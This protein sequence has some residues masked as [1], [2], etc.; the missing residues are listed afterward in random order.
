MNVLAHKDAEK[1]I[2][3]KVD[4]IAFSLESLIIGPDRDPGGEFD[5]IFGDEEKQVDAVI[6]FFT[7]KE[8]ADW[9][10]ETV[11]LLD[12]CYGFDRTTVVVYLEKEGLIPIAL[13]SVRIENCYF[14][15]CEIDKDFP[16]VP[17]NERGM[18]HPDVL[19][20]A[21]TGSI[22]MKFSFGIS[23][24]TKVQMFIKESSTLPLGTFDNVIVK[25]DFIE[26]EGDIV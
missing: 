10:Y 1:S 9:F 6:S 20:K 4:E 15:E 22:K 25:L 3:A 16:H 2:Q 13:P 5:D 11:N 24:L 12:F 23:Q 26:E 14:F 17:Y 18:H 19:K 21:I 7:T 8:S